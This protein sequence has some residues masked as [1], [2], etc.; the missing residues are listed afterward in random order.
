MNTPES[1]SVDREIDRQA[2]EWFGR[3]EVGLSP[4]LEQE[5]QLWLS[6]DRRHAEHY[7]QLDETWDL[8]DGLKELKHLQLESVVESKQV[9]RFL[10]RRWLSVAFAAAAVI[11]VV[12]IFWP[13][14]NSG[15]ASYTIATEVGGM[16]K[17]DLPDGSIVR[18]NSNT[19]VTVKLTAGERRINLQHGEAFFTVAKDTS[20]PFTVSAAGISVRAVGTAFNVMLGRSSLEVLVTEGKVRVEEQA[21]GQ[22]ILPGRRA[23]DEQPSLGTGQKAVVALYP[24]THL[25][26]VAIVVRV[27]PA[28]AEKLLA[29]QAKLLEFDMRPLSEVVAEFNRYNQRQLVIADEALAN[30]VFGGSFRADN[31]EALV[32]LLEDR[33]GVTAERSD[34]KIVLR[35]HK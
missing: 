12:F 6:A 27:P 1:K 5:F 34:E 32:E 11:A 30:R 21:K 31:Y 23:G 20:R 25:A 15:F 4:E 35:A 3:R 24:E 33:F 26:S 10:Y 2:A 16:K 8:L 29:W 14:S 7:R 17:L 22:S 18:L 9:S 19:A 13:R 28:E